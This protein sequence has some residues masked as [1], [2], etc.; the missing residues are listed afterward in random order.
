MSHVG[1]HFI[2]LLGLVSLLANP[3]RAQA[4]WNPARLLPAD[5]LLYVSL[6]PESLINHSGELAMAKLWNSPELAPLLAPIRARLPAALANASA[7]AGL[8]SPEEER[9]FWQL[10]KGRIAVAWLPP[11]AA[12]A[13]P[14]GA[15]TL[16][17]KLAGRP[18]RAREY[19]RRAIE[20]MGGKVSSS[21]GELWEA[22]CVV[23]PFAI[24]VR[25]E[26]D[27]LLVCTDPE[28]LDEMT[29]RSRGLIAQGSLADE[30]AFRRCL[31]VVEQPK[32][33]AIAYFAF[34]RFLQ[35]FKGLMEEAFRDVAAIAGWDG[36]EALSYSF[37]LDGEGI[38]DR[39]FSY[40][41]G[42]TWMK[43]I[44]PE[45][46]GVTLGH[47]LAPEAT[48]LFFV[49]HIDFQ[50][51]YEVALQILPGAHPRIADEI[52]KIRTW[53]LERAGV[54]LRADLLSTLGTEYGIFMAYEGQSALPELHVFAEVKEKER[55]WSAL[56][57]FEEA[58][59][60][61]VRLRRLERKG[62]TYLV[63]E[64]GLSLGVG[65]LRWTLRPTIT[66]HDRY[67]V[68][69][70]YPRA[71]MRLMDGLD[72]KSPRLSSSPDFAAG[73]ARL[74]R[75][76][77]AGAQS[78]FTWIDM[79]A[80]VTTV[81]DHIV[82]PLQLFF[83]RGGDASVF[84]V[85]HLPHR[86]LVRDR[87]FG[88]TMVTENLPDGTYNDC[89]SPTGLL[90]GYVATGAAVG[91]M[92]ASQVEAIEAGPRPLDEEAPTS[93][94]RR[95][96]TVELFLLREAIR[97]YEAEHGRL[98]P[99]DAWFGALAV[100]TGDPPRFKYLSLSSLSNAEGKDPWGHPYQ[101]RVLGDGT[102]ELMSLGADRRTGGA[103]EG[104]DLSDR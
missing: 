17:A 9:E 63:V 88:L 13:R 61:T 59:D 33:V 85:A 86:D 73:R 50:K 55:L 19:L 77:E 42:P 49:T 1:G 11:A 22:T 99:A 3:G 78:G 38:R 47:E 29:D 10:W 95:V 28:R 98:P 103:G 43:Q 92:F 39:L 104:R 4:D 80:A 6:V 52:E 16:I 15:L 62:H 97:Q 14:M 44:A 71:A 54:D 79:R 70:L 74:H 75:E 101:F 102:F 51:A 41:P 57:R 48:R 27:E 32:S 5:T 64:T 94:E 21:E 36:I 45:V 67:L 40:M 72:A 76:S 100:K 69:S 66:V 23:G 8:T 18:E 7:L 30:G 2:A 35:S 91:L 56:D 96:A 82:P 24:R 58:L 31:E 12:E 68:V 37:D 26:R 90:V 93:Q 89:Y 84:P 20:K 53:S 87:L 81:Y 83:M 34:R 25:H 46:P 60:R 65:G